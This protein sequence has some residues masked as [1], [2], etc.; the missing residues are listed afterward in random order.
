MKN[1]RMEC[2]QTRKIGVKSRFQVNE[3]GTT[4]HALMCIARSFLRL[5]SNKSPRR[6]CYIP[7]P[8][9]ANQQPTNSHPTRIY[10]TT[11]RKGPTD[12]FVFLIVLLM[13]YNAAASKSHHAIFRLFPSFHLQ[14]F[15]SQQ[16]VSKMISIRLSILP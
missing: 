16:N 1:K 10:L 9:T 15:T 14:D 12:N 13:F 8:I 2:I 4:R 6:A 7:E 11:F 5:L 3:R